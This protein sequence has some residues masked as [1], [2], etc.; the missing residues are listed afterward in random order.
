MAGVRGWGVVGG[1][2]RQLYLN[3]NKKRER[4]K[5]DCDLTAVGWASSCRP[6]VHWIDS[7]AGHMPGLQARS[8]VGGVQERQQINVSF[9][10]Q[11]FSPSLSPSF[12][13]SLKIS[14]NKIF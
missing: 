11:C 8:P 7:P 4:G 6:K 13:L 2:W 9:A 10:H 3:N 12:P 1:K 5:L 14:K